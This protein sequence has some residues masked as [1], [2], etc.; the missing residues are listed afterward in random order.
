M[1]LRANACLAENLVAA[2]AAVALRPGD[3]VPGRRGQSFVSRP[4]GLVLKLPVQVGG[5]SPEPQLCR[6]PYAGRR[7][8]RCSGLTVELRQAIRWLW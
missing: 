3:Q 6:F 7:C 5:Q 4:Q 2:T 1:G 8:R